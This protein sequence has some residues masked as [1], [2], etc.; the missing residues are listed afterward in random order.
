M[1]RLRALSS[2]PSSQWVAL[3]LLALAALAA[4]VATVW[5]GDVEYPFG[6]LAPLL[7]GVVLLDNRVLSWFVLIEIVLVA[8]IMVGWSRDALEV[9]CLVI[10]LALCLVVLGLVLRGAPIGVAARRG[11]SMLVDLRD[12]ILAQGEIP[13][14][15][16][17]WLVESSL[18]SAGGSPFAGDFVV[19]TAREH[20][21]RL[22]LAL[23]DVSG[24]GE[25]AGIRALQLS[26]AMGGLIGAL[27][28]DSF[29]SAAND[30][31]LSRRWSEG[32]ATAVH[33]SL[34][35]VTGEFQVRAAG[36]PPPVQRHAGSGRW[37]PLRTEGMILGLVE[38]VG[39]DAVCGRLSR[40]DALLLYTD[41]MVEEPHKDIDLGIDALLGTTES[42]L[43]GS[44]EGMAGRL[45]AAVGSRDDDRALLVVHR[46]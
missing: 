6:M 14:L 32:F 30:Y 24:K 7:L 38:G 27:P 5:D 12:R 42:M 45:T 9:A 31:L 16:G 1:R 19:A 4:A 41:G 17:T 20:G 29:L 8:A 25:A 28:P 33:L 13:E 39:Y 43:R 44:W 34:D 3:V 37:E 21:R 26:G 23:V 11:E 2:V 36:H 18:S 46:R 15:P 10:T 22:E 40:G 35:L